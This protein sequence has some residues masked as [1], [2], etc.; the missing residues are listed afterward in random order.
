MNADHVDARGAQG[1]QVG[2]S[3]VQHN[4]FGATPARSSYRLLVERIA[5]PRLE[6]RDAEL[7][8]LA[9]FGTAVEG[10]GY[11]WW[12]AP[13]WAGKSA[14]M[15]TFV[16]RPPPGVRIVSFFVT[17]RFS[18]QNNRI[19]FT[20]VVMEQLAELLG[21]PRP[22][23]VTE[24]TRDHTFLDLLHRAAHACAERRER[25][26]LLVDGLDE[27]RG[28]TLSPEAHSIA[29]LLP[30]DLPAGLRVIVAGRPHPPIPADV[31]DRHPLRDP[32][33]VRALTRS[34]RAAV[35]ENE[36]RREITH[37]LRGSTQERDLV[38][39]VAAAG[40]GL[41][42]ADLAELTGAVADDFAEH[43]ASVAGRSFTPRPGTWQ[44][45]DVYVLGHEELQRAALTRLG[46]QGID[47]YRQRLH[48]W[49]DRYR[50]RS[51]PAQ[52]PEYLVSGYFT[53]LELAGETDRLVALAVDGTR[54]DRMLELSGGDSA[55]LAEIAVAQEAVA[56]APAPDLKA[57]GR[58]AVHRDALAQRNTHI[59]EELPAVWAALGRTARA[60]ALARSITDPAAQ[61]RALARIAAR[62]TGP[63]GAEIRQRAIAVAQSLGDPA[64]RAN[65]L[66]DV[67]RLA[68]APEIFREAEV[69]V[70]QVLVRVARERM[71]CVLVAAAAES[72][73]LA[74][75]AALLETIRDVD[76]RSTAQFS[77]LRARAAAG[78]LDGAEQLAEGMARPEPR[79]RALLACARAAVALDAGRARL[80]ADRA[81][82]A[83]ELIAE[84]RARAWAMVNLVEVRHRTGTPERM[85]TLIAKS[86]AGIDPPEAGAIRSAV[87][88]AVEGASPGSL[89]LDRAE[90][91]ARTIAT[92]SGRDRALSTLVEVAA[93]N[94]ET[95]RAE[96]LA[97]L[98]EGAAH[99][100]RADVALVA[101]K[102]RAG[103]LTWALA[104][105]GRVESTLDGI[106]NRGERSQ[107][108]AAL[109]GALRR[110]DENRAVE[111]AGRAE[112]TARLIADPAEHAA[113]ARDLA[114]ALAGLGQFD[115]ALA[116]AAASGG[117]RW[118]A[119]AEGDLAAA[120][121]EADDFVRAEEIAH[122]ITDHDERDAALSRLVR[123]AITARR[124]DLAIIIT[125][126]IKHPSH[127]SDARSALVAALAEAGDLEVARALAT[128]ILDQE[129]RDR[130]L[131][132]V[133]RA[134]A[135]SADVAVALR[136]VE[137]I[138]DEGNRE[139]ARRILVETVARQGRFDHAVSVARS[140]RFPPRRRALL[141]EVA[142][143]AA[144]LGDAWRGEELVSL[145]D[146]DGDRVSALIALVRR[147]AP[148]LGA[149]A[150]VALAGRAEDLARLL[151]RQQ[152]ESA[153]ADLAAVSA[154]L[155]EVGLATDL[156]REVI[157]IGR[158]ARVWTRLAVAA[159]RAGAREEAMIWAT[160]AQR[161]TT[162]AQA[163]ELH[164]LAAVVAA[165]GH[166]DQ[167]VHLVKR[168]SFVHWGGL[169]HDERAERW[170]S[171]VTTTAELGG[172]ARARDLA[173]L[174]GDQRARAWAL[175][176]AATA[177]RKAG[178]T[179]LLPVLI[180]LSRE[181]AL[182]VED[183][184]QRMRALTE[185]IPAAAGHPTAVARIVSLLADASPLVTP[186]GLRARRLIAAIAAV[187][188]AGGDATR[189]VGEADSA[190]AVIGAS[191]EK[192]RA[193][194]ALA[195][196]ADGE[197]ARALVVRAL[198]AGPWRISLTRLAAIDTAAVS[199]MAAQFLGDDRPTP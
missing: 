176:S 166:P 158:K 160:R 55:A 39:L 139:A 134:V 3:G 49:A 174:I 47:T 73:D 95:D 128:S 96:A 190:V 80:A 132:A 75:A 33:I 51:W 71:T 133:V 69:A 152:R 66:L 97:Y 6:G 161:S 61:A 86:A 109:A 195:G 99:R 181:A 4:Y 104:L 130:A 92:R 60:Q 2:T 50:E 199:A 131:S 156:L 194:V 177:A 119:Q 198:A 184:A 98:I 121:A 179:E 159:V 64:G 164:E 32:A 9:A 90:F 136:A 21:E 5:P 25:L 135:A 16:L 77:L 107:V 169:S 154:E 65:A 163:G 81:E 45:E 148:T 111:L 187:Q 124:L 28:V 189:L 31:P 58:L 182:T 149:E 140:A 72:D 93:A 79:V 143:I 145:L 10:A 147:A 23:H 126:S 36:M 150:L 108:L 17:A 102:A 146:D 171:V 82:Q 87:A 41:S 105:A 123:V 15:A 100:A 173:V 52:T 188:S 191:V 22:A 162:Q 180:D 103:D 141:A 151:P 74:T 117:A 19:A 38:G 14:L 1:L 18:N 125:R 24:A 20:D 186:A 54:H 89:H 127:V 63:A 110:A 101:A 27:D 26:I 57:L 85:P 13:A 35:V 46:R 11:T 70:A 157:D 29:A 192:A 106:E 142:H 183:P 12:R 30:A 193:L 84:P 185:T 112:W 67:L 153:L 170:K 120:A 116:V 165:A 83:A 94:G 76:L 196:V 43:L 115:R 88:R 197:R 113:G 114:R 7:A 91:Q 178:E 175:S 56:A 122:A 34:P 37:L 78:D 144:D 118:Q 137:A 172:W 59:A 168:T 129:H 138:A 167:A 48:A 155:G 42:A 53:M 62:V 44:P 68:P 40:G 8:E